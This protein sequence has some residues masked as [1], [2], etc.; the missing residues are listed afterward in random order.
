VWQRD[1]TLAKELINEI[2]GK[3]ASRIGS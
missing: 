1:R 2:E 3:T